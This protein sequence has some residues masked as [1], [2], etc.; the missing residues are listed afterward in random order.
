MDTEVLNQ[1]VNMYKSVEEL[2]AVTPEELCEVITESCPIK[3]PVD[4]EGGL[5]NFSL[6]DDAHEHYENLQDGDIC[7]YYDYCDDDLRGTDDRTEVNALNDWLYDVAWPTVHKYMRD[8]EYEEVYE[9]DGS[10][11][12]LMYGMVVFRKKVKPAIDLS[13][14]PERLRYLVK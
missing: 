10:G 14:I 13:K 1:G 5:G 4:E 7:V 3:N 2:L 12:G 8:N 9:N 11:N 6:L